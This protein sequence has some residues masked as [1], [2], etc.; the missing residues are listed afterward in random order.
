MN[1]GEVLDGGLGHGDARRAFRGRR[2]RGEKRERKMAHS[3]SKLR[4]M[5]PVPGID[6]V[7]RF[8]FRDASAFHNSHQ[9]QTSIGKS[10][11]TIGEADQRQHRTRR[12]DF[13]VSRAGSLERGERKDNVADRAG[14]NKQATVARNWQV[15]G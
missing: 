12:P 3:I 6:G 13:G 1:D 9:I 5:G 10:P 7:E 14:A 4:T 8:Q 2:K 15:T 11:G